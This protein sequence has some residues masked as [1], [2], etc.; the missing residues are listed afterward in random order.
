MDVT[1][2]ANQLSLSMEQSKR[3]E[4]FSGIVSQMLET[5]QAKNSDYGNSFAKL[6]QTYPNSIAL[7]LADKLNRLETLCVRGTEQRVQ[8]SIEDTL[9]DIATYAVMELV[10]RKIDQQCKDDAENIA[11]TLEHTVSLSR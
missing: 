7:R 1:S 3:T 8:E 2:I 4:Y 5:Y 10:E 6:R 9:L 11:F